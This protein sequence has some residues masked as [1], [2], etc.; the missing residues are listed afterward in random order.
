MNTA[1]LH[2]EGSYASTAGLMNAPRDKN[3]LN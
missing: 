2:L 1:N 3:A